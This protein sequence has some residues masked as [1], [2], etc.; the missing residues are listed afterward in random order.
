MITLKD[1]LYKVSL[2]KVVGNTAVAF[3]ELQFDSR[4]VGLDDVFV[5]I[6]GTQSDGHQFIKALWL[7]FASKYQK[8]LL[9]ALP[10]CRYKTP[11]RHWR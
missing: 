11:N 7:W 6:K 10:T 3:R 5:A 8:R 9:M 2:E 4:K 1:I